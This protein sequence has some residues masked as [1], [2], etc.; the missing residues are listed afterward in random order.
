MVADPE[1]PAIPWVSDLGAVLIVPSDTAST[2]VV[3][4][5]IDLD[6]AGVP[7]TP[8]ALIAPSGDSVVSPASIVP[9]SSVCGVAPIA[10]LSGAGDAAWSVALGARPAA[11]VPI[12]SIRGMRSADSSRFAA[13]LARLASAV[14]SPRDSRFARL[15]FVV[16][17]GHR[18]TLGDTSVAIGHLVRRI[19]Q[20]AAPLEEHT[21]IVAERAPDARAFASSYSFR[22][23]ATEDSAEVID[24]LAVARS[25]TAYLVLRRESSA[26]TVYVILERSASGKWTE[27]WSRELAC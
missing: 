11:I 19:P 5:P 23:E 27:R 7:A 21:F 9:D 6:S 20:E 17:A 15:P 13:D 22:A 3:V 10:R 14:P 2:G 16:L 24:V 1:P 4:F 18:L 25:T 12:D 8:V 26:R